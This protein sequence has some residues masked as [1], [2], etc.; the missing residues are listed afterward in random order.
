MKKYGSG[1]FVQF[2]FSMASYALSDDGRVDGF[3]IYQG[4]NNRFDGVENIDY[5]D[6]KTLKY[7][8][9][10]Y[11]LS[12]EN[13]YY[14]QI[15]SIISP[16]YEQF[17]CFSKMVDYAKKHS[18]GV[19]DIGDIT[20]YI[21][22]EENKLNWDWDSLAIK[23]P[24]KVIIGKQLSNEESGT[25]VLDLNE[26]YIAVFPLYDVVISNDDNISYNI[27]RKEAFTIFNTV[28]Q[29]LSGENGYIVDAQ[30]YPYCPNLIEAS[31][32]FRFYDNS[33]GKTYPVFSIDATS[34]DHICEVDL[35]PLDDVKKEYIEREYSIISPD[36]NGKFTFNFY[37][38]KISKSKL[39]I[40]IKTALKPFSIVSSAVIIPDEGSL[41]NMTYESDLRGCMST[42]NGFECSLASSAFETY[43]RQNSNYQQLFDLDKQEL[44]KQHAVEFANDVTATIVNTTS[45]AT[46]GAI[47]GASMADAGFFDFIPGVKS[48]SKVAGAAIGATAAGVTVGAAMS[49]QTALNNDLRNYEEE[50]Q[51]K[52]FDLNIQTIKNL[53]N[54]VNRI[55]SFNEIL[56]RDDSFWFVIETYECTDFEK[57]VV[58]N[59]IEKY[60]YGI[61]VFDDIIKYVKNGN[62]I[63][64]T[65]ISSKYP[66]VLNNIA[67]N[68]LKGGIYY[69]E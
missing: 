52:R 59:F 17:E 50:L 11:K 18:E 35:S 36:K 44:Q 1:F 34:F 46:M 16:E 56:F 24:S 62:F 29:Y 5:Y 3:V 27:T 8:D 31:N 12:V 20:S 21:L 66:I 49:L 41:M 65:L 32:T 6:K 40:K 28:I 22:Y 13:D 48:A 43:K 57:S 19:D 37:D 54:S 69:F 26:Q 25:F 63:R 61:G 38:Y 30:V 58:D 47:A 42:S 10:Y 45:A 64:S 53:P 55:S 51:Q 9:K 39:R 14:R 2:A 67:N 7:N 23:I 33:I 60:G 68:E 4:E 15:A